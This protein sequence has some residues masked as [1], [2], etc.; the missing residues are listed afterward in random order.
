MLIAHLHADGQVMM[1]CCHPHL[2]QLY[3]VS[4]EPPM[5]IITEYMSNG[6]LLDYLR[7]EGTG[8][9]PHRQNARATPLCP[10]ACAGSACS[11]AM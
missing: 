9:F 10:M 1:E 3:G 6:C 11:Y 8:C 2:V 5:Y 7:D 4:S